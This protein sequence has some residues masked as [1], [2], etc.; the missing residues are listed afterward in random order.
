MLLDYILIDEVNHWERQLEGLKVVVPKK[1]KNRRYCSF[2]M[3]WF[4]PFNL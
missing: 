3:K 2:I 1:P 4:V